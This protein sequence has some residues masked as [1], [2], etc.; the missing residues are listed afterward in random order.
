MAM[1][2]SERK[3]RLWERLNRLEQLAERQQKELD[4]LRGQHN[5]LRAIVFELREEIKPTDV[6]AFPDPGTG[7]MAGIAIT[8]SDVRGRY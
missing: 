7:S 5:E 1:G 3:P 6:P 8:T 4:E 2:P